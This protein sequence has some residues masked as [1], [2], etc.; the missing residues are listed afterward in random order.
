[1]KKA[2]SDRLPAVTLARL[3]A[4]RA[5][6]DHGSFAA[7]ARALR[8]SH[9]AIAQ[10]VHALE[11]IQGTP[12][13]E[14][15]GIVLKPTPLA[16]ELCEIADRITQEFAE[17]E[18]VLARRDPSGRRRLKIGLGNSMPGM[19]LIKDVLAA[20][21]DL[22]VDVITG[23]HGDIMR[24]VL[25]RQVELGV[26]PDV[27]L[28]PRFR[29]TV[30]LRQQ[31]VAI[32][33]AHHPLAE[34]QSTSLLA[35][36]EHPLIFRSH[37]S[38]TQ[39]VV[40]RAFERSGLSPKPVLVADTR[41]AVYEAVALGVGVGFMWCYGTNRTDTVRR[42]LVCELKHD[43]EECLFALADERDPVVNFVFTLA[44]LWKQSWMRER[45]N[46]RH[47]RRLERSLR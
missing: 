9:A 22:A 27:P 44:D 13:F 19:A 12:L 42:I 33:G 40:D 26:L 16:C 8:Q 14:R 47:E 30:L 6:V 10:A 24:A 18:R 17:A 37:G 25:K 39:R 36:I 7:A 29:R 5:V 41:D 38:S 3:R 35:L 45:G 21:R 32:A 43:V 46:A 31:V 23:S 34:T 28:D 1:M 15:T 2:L 11:A 4:V 20:Q